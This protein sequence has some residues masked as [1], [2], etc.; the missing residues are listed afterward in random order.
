MSYSSR[1]SKG[2]HYKSGNQGSSHYKKKGLFGNMFDILGSG[3]GSGRRTQHNNMGHPSQTTQTSHQPTNSQNTT[4]CGSCNA[5]IPAGSKFCLQCG[6]K[7]N[8][9]AFCLNCG[10]KLPPGSKFC[11]SCGQKVNQ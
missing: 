3:S 9:A 1:S 4:V 11:L 8:T 6:Q 10:E 2:K 5:T 7:V